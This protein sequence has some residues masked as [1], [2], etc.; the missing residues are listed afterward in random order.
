MSDMLVSSNES[1]KS[2]DDCFLICGI[3]WKKERYEV[4]LN[5]KVNNEEERIWSNKY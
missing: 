2:F 3:V 4:N 1:L 5:V